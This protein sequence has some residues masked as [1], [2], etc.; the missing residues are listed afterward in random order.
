MSQS[1]ARIRKNKKLLRRGS[2]YKTATEDDLQ[3]TCV[4]WFRLEYPR[5]KW[6]LWHTPNG[7]FR[8]VK[9]A[10]KLKRIGVVAGIPDLFLAYPVKNYAGLF[11][12][13]KWGDN[14]LTDKQKKQCDLLEE[15]GYKVVRGCRRFRAFQK[16][17]REY[18]SDV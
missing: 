16:V 18:L 1:K 6:L 14:K 7:G 2:G 15:Q 12:E 4:K 3:A 8:N 10:S 11:I 13:L 5:L 9:E 17:V